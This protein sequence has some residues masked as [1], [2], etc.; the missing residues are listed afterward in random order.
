[1]KTKIKTLCHSIG[2][3]ACAGALLM[4]SSAFAQNLLVA[5]YTPGV[6]DEITPGGTVS[7]FAAGLNYPV[8]MGLR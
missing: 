3:A 2:A 1:M 4:G 6:I 7:S 8:G 5:N